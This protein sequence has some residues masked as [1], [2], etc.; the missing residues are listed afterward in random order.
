[1]MDYEGVDEGDIEQGECC[2][3]GWCFLELVD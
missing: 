2:D 3:G 1:V